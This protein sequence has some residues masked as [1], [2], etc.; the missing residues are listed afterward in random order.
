MFVIKVVE[1]WFAPQWFSW[2]K[3]KENSETSNSEADD[4]SEEE[5]AF[6][7][8]DEDGVSFFS[9]KEDYLDVVAGEDEEALNFPAVGGQSGAVEE[10]LMVE[11]LGKQK[12]AACFVGDEETSSPKENTIM[13][14]W[15]IVG[16]VLGEQKLH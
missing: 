1:D 13:K 16:V 5:G 9:R 15:R 8:G 2:N 3:A 10:A 14:T 7:E 4:E 6:D 12:T 11:R